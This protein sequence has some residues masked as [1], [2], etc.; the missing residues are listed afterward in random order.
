MKVRITQDTEAQATYIYLIEGSTH[1]HTIEMPNGWNIDFDTDGNIRGIEILE[2]LGS[3]VINDITRQPGEEAPGTFDC[4]LEALER[5][6][7]EHDDT[8]RNPHTD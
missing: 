2:L 7:V 6:K 4:D 1:S 5:R 8:P 3:L